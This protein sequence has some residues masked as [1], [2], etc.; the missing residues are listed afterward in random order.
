MVVSVYDWELAGPGEQEA[1]H[2][3]RF[4]FP[5]GRESDRHRHDGYAEVTW[6]IDGHGTHYLADVCLQ[7]SVGDVFFIRE[8]D[9]HHYI[10]GPTG[11]TVLNAAIPTTLLADAKKRLEGLEIWPWDRERRY[12]TLGAAAM[13]RL[14]YWAEELQPHYLHTADVIAFLADLV[15]QSAR[16]DR[17][18]GQSP[19]P[20]W[21][22]AAIG[23]WRTAD[24]LS[25]GPGAFAAQCGRSSDH[26]NRAVRASYGCTTSALLLRL[27]LDRAASL[28]R[29]SDHSVLDIA[30]ITGFSNQGYFH[31]CFK[32]RFGTTPRA[33]RYR[34]KTV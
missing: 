8:Q 33:Y 11:L 2:I 22:S 26:V 13:S 7:A 6:V 29:L 24:D 20:P 25:A 12:G 19:P 14:A 28:L 5:P 30:F 4:H 18:G 16:A 34:R 31:R 17:R 23:H 3:G 21:L 15:R 1:M 27:R 10:G 9:S 32:D